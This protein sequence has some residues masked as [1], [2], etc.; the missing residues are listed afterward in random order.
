M[1][2]AL[3]LLERMVFGILLVSPLELRIGMD[4]TS[5]IFPKIR[6]AAIMFTFAQAI[7]CHPVILMTCFR[8]GHQS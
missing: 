1:T 8:W 7:T 4:H 6:G 3:T 5:I 2:L